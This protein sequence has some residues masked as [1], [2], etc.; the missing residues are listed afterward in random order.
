MFGCFGD[1]KLCLLTYIAPCYTIGKTAESVGEDGVKFTVLSMVPI[2]NII[3]GAKIRGKVRAQKGIDG[4]DMMDLLL[5]CCCPFCA[6]I[7]E[8]QEMNSVKVEE[9][10]I[11][12]C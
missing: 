7:Q 6:V 11:V 4:T 9:L 1:I 10:A 12:R 8:A 2:A 3:C 5:H